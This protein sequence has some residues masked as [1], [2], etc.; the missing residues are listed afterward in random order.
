MLPKKDYTHLKDVLDN[1]LCGFNFKGGAIRVPKHRSGKLAFSHRT[2]FPCIKQPPNS[3]R[4]AYYII[5]RM[6]E[7]VLD[8]KQLTLPSHIDRWG[9]D[10]ANS[11]D[12]D[13]RLE[14][15]RIQQSL[16]TIICKDVARSDGMF[17]GGN[18]D[19]SEISD[20]LELQGD[21]QPFNTIGGMRLFP[22]RSNR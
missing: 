19:R 17:F 1:A 16:G 6:R 21:E 15:Y 20:R 7:F 8:Q 13:L 22:V 14:F 2:E 3:M 18:P 11:S 12:E 5:H 4:D 10:L 9:Q